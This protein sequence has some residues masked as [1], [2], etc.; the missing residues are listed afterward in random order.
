M[1]IARHC[2]SLVAVAGLTLSLGPGFQGEP[3][4]AEAPGVSAA[5]ITAVY[6]VNL[7][8]INLGDFRVTTT[9]QGDGYQ[10]R[11][12]GSFNVLEGLIFRW[13]G[14]TSSRGRVTDDGPAPAMYAFSYSNGGKKSE[15]LHM[16]FGDGAVQQVSIVPRTGTIPGI[17]HRAVGEPERRPQRLQSIASSIRRQVALRSRAEAKEAGHGTEPLAEFL[18]GA[19]RSVPG[20]V[21]SHLGLSAERSRDQAY[22]AIQRDRGLADAGQGH[23]YV[24]ALSYWSADAH[25]LWHRGD[26]IDPSLGRAARET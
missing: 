17:P 2:L 4:R 25:G 10:T 5:R 1:R 12:E 14:V 15:R 19:C 11:G 3:A 21:H 16:T 22:V 18:F 9:L 7:G 20:K 8:R 6:Q 24:C 26:N 23:R 13:R